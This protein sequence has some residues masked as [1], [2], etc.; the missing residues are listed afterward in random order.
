MK[1]LGLFGLSKRLKDLSESGDPLEKLKEIVNFEL[2]RDELEKGLN[3]SEGLKGGRPACDA[4][5]IFKILILQTLY[6]LSD[7][8][9][10]YQ[11][12]DRLSFMRFL[13]LHLSD[14]VPDAKTNWLYRER[15]SKNGLIDHVFSKFGEMLVNQGYLAMGGQIVDASIVQAPRQR[16]TREEKAQIKKGEIPTDWQAKPHKL[17]QKDRDARW[18]VKYT[19]AKDDNKNSVDL[20]IPS[21]GYKNHIS[22]DRRF[23]FIRKTEITAANAYD[24]HFLTSLLDLE[25]TSRDVYGDTAYSTEDNL[26]YLENHGF[27]SKLHRKKPKRKPMPLLLKKGNTTKSKI[28]AHVEHVFAVQKEQMNLFVR[29]IGLKRAKVKIGLA[30]ITYNIKRLI[31]FEKRKLTTG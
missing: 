9:I 31:F 15:F 12:Q 21:F 1:E 16:M 4:D 3:F 23:G 14:K 20:A 22:I 8:Q 26:N 11:I 5:L 17:A 7:E 2:F 30:N 27:C 6:N 10:E 24:G 19:K 13:D 29:T 18:I 28:R 25:N